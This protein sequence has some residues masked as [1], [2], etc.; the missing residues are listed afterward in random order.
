[1]KDLYNYFFKQNSPTYFL[2][3]LHKQYYAGPGLKSNNNK[4]LQKNKQLIKFCSVLFNWT[5]VT[6]PYN[7]NNNNKYN[8]S[9]HLRQSCSMDVGYVK[10]SLGTAVWALQ[11]CLHY[12][13]STEMEWEASVEPFQ[14]MDRMVHNPNHILSSNREKIEQT[15][16]VQILYG[17]EHPKWMLFCYTKIT[18]DFLT[19][20]S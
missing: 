19:I 17:K 7:D 15:I 6:I 5:Q 18:G 9:S 13:S 4:Q 16:I 8:F 20:W 2:V 1:M 10:E 12:R 11:T 3:D 14:K